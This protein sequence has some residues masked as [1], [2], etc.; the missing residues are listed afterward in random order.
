MHGITIT[1]WLSASFWPWCNSVQLVTECM[2][3]WYLPS[4]M[5]QS[6]PDVTVRTHGQQ[7][8]CYLTINLPLS[9]YKV[10]HRL[11]GVHGITTQPSL[12]LHHWQSL[13]QA[14]QCMNMVNNRRYSSRH[15]QHITNR[16]WIS[17]IF[18]YLSWFNCGFV[19]VK[20]G[21]IP[22]ISTRFILSH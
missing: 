14:Y 16:N 7:R 17:I 3:S 15:S 5:V 9:V 13:I 21:L 12:S 4:C 2:A 20:N 6:T 19:A 1:A 22:K 8:M 18:F 10:N 11:C